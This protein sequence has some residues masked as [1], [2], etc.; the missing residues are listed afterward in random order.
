[1]VFLYYFIDISLYQIFFVFY[2]RLS[3]SVM[4]QIL[5]FV[6]KALPRNMLK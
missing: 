1:M 6:L 4:T 2:C 5:F 3:L